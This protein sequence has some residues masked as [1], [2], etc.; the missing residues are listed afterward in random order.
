MAP[1]SCQLVGGTAKHS[2]T[3]R[4]GLA[5][6]WQRRAMATIPESTWHFIKY[7]DEL[8][9]GFEILGASRDILAPIHPNTL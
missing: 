8:A 6:A 4:V 7:S 5:P 9:L 2:W 3:I 1:R